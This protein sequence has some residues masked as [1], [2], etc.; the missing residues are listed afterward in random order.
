MSELYPLRIDARS[1][2]G[3]R[4]VDT[5]LLS[6]SCLPRPLSA[7][8]T[9]EEGI[10]GNVRALADSVITDYEVQALQPA[11][12][13][14]NYY[15]GRES[16][17]NL[18]ELR[19]DVEHQI[20]TALWKLVD[21]TD[22]GGGGGGNTSGGPSISRKR[23]SEVDAGTTAAEKEDSS[24]ADTG[25]EVSKK[26]KTEDD[27]DPAA[28]TEASEAAD[29]D[30]PR[31]ETKTEA[32]TKSSGDTDEKEPAAIATSDAPKSSGGKDDSTCTDTTCTIGTTSTKP[33]STIDRSDL[34]K[35]RIRLRYK[36]VVVLDEFY[37][38][39]T[40]P[41]DLPG[42]DLL[43][44]AKSLVKD[45]NLPEEMTTAIVTTIIEQCHGLV[46][47]PDLDGVKPPRDGKVEPS[48]ETPAA[49]VVTTI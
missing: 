40:F 3:Y 9:T 44:V 41:T 18:P 43:S 29:D 10:E 30:Q 26:Q 14:L 39:P 27:Q 25:A 2:N 13:R 19:A 5:L 33:I 23:K 22:C 32:E 37:V 35:I 49:F 1:T 24:G 11:G 8:R 34:V 46:I 31:K 6:P 48:R 21:D 36:R 4:L 15:T 12:Y 45:L 47:P 42:G 20:R 7:Y 16:L 38:D 28:V 17:L